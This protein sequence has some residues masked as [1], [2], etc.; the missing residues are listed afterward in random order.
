MTSH[1]HA[2]GRAQPTSWLKPP[3][4]SCAPHTSHL[5][6][7][8]PHRASRHAAANYQLA[9]LIS[10]AVHGDV[11]GAIDAELLHGLT[12]GLET[13]KPPGAAH[14]AHRQKSAEQAE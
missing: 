3:E 7:A 5:T 11:Q 10:P 13:V 12:G 2:E 8:R 1:V 14:L 4:D 9:Q 6:H